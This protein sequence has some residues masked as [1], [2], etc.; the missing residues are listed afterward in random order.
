MALFASSCSQG[1][2]FPPAE[3]AKAPVFTNAKIF[4]EPRFPTPGTYEYGQL[5]TRGPCLILRTSDG[6]EYS[7]V[8]PFGS[9]FVRNDRRNLL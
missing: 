4:A 5:L 6:M 8:L 9:R 2:I 1:E 3:P 7:S